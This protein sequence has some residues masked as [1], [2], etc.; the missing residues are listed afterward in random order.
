VRQALGLVAGGI[1]QG[2]SRLLDPRERLV[3]RGFC[4]QVG[5]H[6]LGD[7]LQGLLLRLKG[8]EREVSRG[9]RRVCGGCRSWRGFSLVLSL[10][11]W[12][13]TILCRH[14]GRLLGRLYALLLE[15]P[16]CVV[17]L[18]KASYVLSYKIWPP[19]EANG[20]NTPLLNSLIVGRGIVDK[21]PESLDLK[22]ALEFQ[23]L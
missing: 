17:V 10:E 21:Y 1:V 5:S 7:G 2:S 9:L 13:S 6:G 15:L 8:W 19:C 20:A 16:F 18:K 22:A 4:L 23:K 11:R 3:R 14:L 12:K